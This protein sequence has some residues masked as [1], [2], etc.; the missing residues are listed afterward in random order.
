MRYSA[1]EMM[2]VVAAR[3]LRDGEIVFVGIGLPNLACN[4]ARATHAPG[5]VLIY[6]SGAVG[7]LP[8]RLP[9]SIGDPSLVTGSLMVTGMADIFQLFLQGGRIEVGF[10]GGAQIDKYGNINTTV[11]GSY[12]HPKVRLPGSGGAA[13]IATHAQRTLIISRLSTRAF[14]ETVDFITSPGNRSKGKS[15]KEWGMPGA[16]PVKVIT[17]RGILVASDEDG[18]MELAALYPNV[19][20]EDVTSRV[21]WTLRVRDR[22]EAVAPPTA[23]ELRLLREVLDP[24]KL[25]LKGS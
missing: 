25:Y 8:E 19:A 10:L 16:G 6:E 17:D 24:G 13:E 11:V 20:S 2:T 14:P 22:L 3:E 18:E 12:A 5:L 21:G 15:R 7:A 4:L 9:V 23:A 1:E